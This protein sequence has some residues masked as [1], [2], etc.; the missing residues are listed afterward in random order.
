MRNGGGLAAALDSARNYVAIAEAECAK[1]P[2]SAATDALQRAP[3]A[4]LDSLVD[5]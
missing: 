3:R 5:L 2:A 1:L 4:L